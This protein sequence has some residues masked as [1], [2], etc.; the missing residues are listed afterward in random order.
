[1]ITTK[2]RLLDD[3]SLGFADGEIRISCITLGPDEQVAV[4]IDRLNNKARLYAS[5]DECRRLASQHQYELVW[6]QEQNEAFRNWLVHG[7]QHSVVSAQ[8]GTS[9]AR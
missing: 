1:M 7:H 6:P 4:L 9:F 5:L 8:P 3:F 2:G